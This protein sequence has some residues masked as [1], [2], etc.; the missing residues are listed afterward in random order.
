[1]S[2]EE[3]EKRIAE[4]RQK[5]AWVRDLKNTPGWDFVRQYVEAQVM[6]RRQ[7]LFNQE[8]RDLENCFAIARSQGEVAG[9]TLAMGMA[10]ILEDDLAATLRKLEQEGT[11][12]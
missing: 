8:I 3:R 10:Q 4:L 12:E 2:P 9:M 5:R 6:A 1:M 11:E 7:S